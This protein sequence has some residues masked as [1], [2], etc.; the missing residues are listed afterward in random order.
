[1]LLW[2]LLGKARQR[3]QK[4]PPLRA[5]QRSLDPACAKLATIHLV[6]PAPWH[7]NLQFAWSFG[8]FFHAPLWAQIPA[9]VEGRRQ[10]ANAA[11]K[12]AVP[13]ALAPSGRRPRPRRPAT[14]AP[15]DAEG[16]ASEPPSSTT[17][18][19]VAI[20]PLRARLERRLGSLP[21]PPLRQPEGAFPHCNTPSPS[22]CLQAAVNQRYISSPT[23]CHP[24]LHPPMHTRPVETRDGRARLAHCTPSLVSLPHPAISRP[25]GLACPPATSTPS[26]DRRCH[27][28][29]VNRSLP[30][31]TLGGR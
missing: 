21:V 28:Q 27:L 4:Q 26:E 6:W 8:A 19:P 13:L 9:Q 10:R 3:Q 11:N 22:G 17:C 25:D 24:R 15:V 18:L 1:M 16:R 14:A 5:A 29:L 31:D 20:L 7:A 2:Q 30:S 12:Q 23:A